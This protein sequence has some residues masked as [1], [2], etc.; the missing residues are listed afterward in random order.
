M[1]TDWAMKIGKMIC[2]WGGMLCRQVDE[3]IIQLAVGG[4]DWA[5]E[6]VAKKICRLANC[7]DL[8]DDNEQVPIH[9][10]S[11][12]CMKIF[13]PAVRYILKTFLTSFVAYMDGN[14]SA[15]VQQKLYFLAQQA[16]LF[17]ADTCQ[18]TVQDF[19][20][21]I[22]AAFSQDDWSLFGTV[23]LNDAKARF[24][25]CDFT[26]STNPD[27][28]SYLMGPI[29]EGGGTPNGNLYSDCDCPFGYA[30]QGKPLEPGVFTA[31]CVKFDFDQTLG[32]GG[33]D[34]PFVKQRKA[35]VEERRMHRCPVFGDDTTEAEIANGARVGVPQELWIQET[36]ISDD[37]IVNAEETIQT[38]TCRENGFDIKDPKNWQRCD[39][40]YDKF[41]LDDYG[42]WVAKSNLPV[43]DPDHPLQNGCKWRPEMPNS[44]LHRLE[45]NWTCTGNDV[46]AKKYGVLGRCRY[47]D[48]Y[49][50][51]PPPLPPLP[52]F[53]FIDYSGSTFGDGYITLLGVNAFNDAGVLQT[54]TSAE[55][56]VRQANG[57]RPP[58]NCINEA[59]NDGG[60]SLNAFNGNYCV[61][62]E[63][64][65][66]LRIMYPPGTDVSKV[67]IKNRG[68]Y[69]SQRLGGAKV[70]VG[71]GQP[72]STDEAVANGEQYG[73]T[74]PT[75]T[76][77]S[78]SWNDAHPVGREWE[79]LK[80]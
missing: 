24:G 45:E 43:D 15:G 69:W 39:V 46:V 4:V 35:I 74:V 51:V 48:T 1:D 31:P 44:G 33:E 7:P 11:R 38:T 36:D 21:G 9:P 47:S 52:V 53:V 37:V 26:G 71:L 61:S 60:T 3:L 54:A 56:S 80:P 16:D 32:Q 49:E 70:Y 59:A 63:P 79:F 41:K 25:V 30:P 42:D 27:C 73:N 72:E 17:V 29:E 23:A 20:W 75:L 40:D 66:W 64:R 76:R 50:L 5:I 68:G 19:A 58:E 62:G 57:M 22:Y 55:F 2:K 6:W 65:G 28:G 10:M 34:T 13:P 12:I 8:G 67:V 18:E 78:Q 14:P 77:G